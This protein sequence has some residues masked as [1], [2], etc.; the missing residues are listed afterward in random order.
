M[1]WK[2]AELND[3]QLSI[4]IVFYCFTQS[5][6]EKWSVCNEMV[7]F[8]NSSAR[9]GSSLFS[10]AK[11]R[12]ERPS[13]YCTLVWVRLSARYF[14]VPWCPLYC[15]YSDIRRP[16]QVEMY[17]MLLINHVSAYANKPLTLF[18]DDVR[19]MHSVTLLSRKDVCGRWKNLPE[20]TDLQI[21]EKLLLHISSFSWENI[22]NIK[23]K[24]VLENF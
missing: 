6:I 17:S 14:Q 12:S 3:L 19:Y 16:Q 9:A 24:V 7:K 8:L 20:S 18:L 11:F 4:L 15:A 22:M 23:R 5:T 10:T 2:F 1:S 13:G 21:F